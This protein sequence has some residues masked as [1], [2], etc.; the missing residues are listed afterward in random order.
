MEKT[1]TGR[2]LKRI[3]TDEMQKRNFVSMKRK[4]IKKKRGKDTDTDIGIETRRGEG[5]EMEKRGDISMEG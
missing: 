1:Y 4:V 5:S 2:E 3:K